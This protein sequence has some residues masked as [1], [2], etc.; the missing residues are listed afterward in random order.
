MNWD[1]EHPESPSGMG[2]DPPGVYNNIVDT[3]WDCCGACVLRMEEAEIL[4]FPSIYM[5]IS[6]TLA[7]RDQCGTL[8]NV[9][10]HVTI[11]IKPGGLSTISFSGSELI[12]VSGST[13]G[14]FDPAIP[15]SC[16]TYGAADPMWETLTQSWD[17]TTT[18]VTT[19]YV[20]M[21]PPYWPILSPPV[22]LLEYD[23]TWKAKCPYWHT[24]GNNF[25]AFYHG[26]FDPPRI[27]TPVSAMAP[28]TTSTSHVVKH[29]PWKTA[30]PAGI[31]SLNG[32][33]A[34]STALARVEPSVSYASESDVDPTQSSADDPREPKGTLVQSTPV[35]TILN[36]EGG[37]KDSLS[38]KG[39]PQAGS[40]PL[41]DSSTKMIPSVTIDQP[42]VSA[43][44]ALFYSIGEQTLSPGGPAI[45]ISGTSYSMAD[46][47]TA[48][49][50]GS[51]T[52][53]LNAQSNPPAL[54]INGQVYSADTRPRLKFRGSEIVAG[55]PTITISN[56]PYALDP[57]ATALYVGS[58]TIVNPSIQQ[59]TSQTNPPDNE[60]GVAPAYLIIGS[61]T[62][63]L[64]PPA[65]SQPQTLTINSTP[66]TANPSSAFIIGTQTLSPGSPAITINST[67]YSLPPL[68]S[69]SFS[70]SSTP[71]AAQIQAAITVNSTVYTCIQNTPCTIA[72][73]VL[74][75]NGTITVGAETL[76][77][78]P[79]GID[80]ISATAI[81][82]TASRGE[83][84][85]SHVDG[86]VP[87]GEETDTAVPGT[88]EVEG[89]ASIRRVELGLWMCI[90]L[91]I[92]FIRALFV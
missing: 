9:Y 51:S 32:P 47:A 1:K 38:Q 31:I 5:V 40:D 88:G 21:G 55:G 14:S 44:S 54:S 33:S 91:G 50:V 73:Q 92:L 59:P 27:L 34:T 81:V 72:S 37:S 62:T 66:Y 4:T 48:L 28:Q 67:L 12:A 87:I 7:V 29:A 11:P 61:S 30:A 25:D 41:L 6:G 19:S 10:S 85:T 82:E 89:A 76:V 36:S 8:G 3:R 2:Y 63:T 45:T 77:Y 75:P 79:G 24:A 42:I 35:S 23:P 60:E 71:T 17:D 15:P 65:K 49:L 13:I 68:P 74:R 86:L 26:I 69:P 20:T 43:D 83:I 84:I 57:S 52:I 80:V 18:T 46:G 16:R 78:G 90:V 39:G 58:G 22:E 53:P 64:Q 70:S 56:V